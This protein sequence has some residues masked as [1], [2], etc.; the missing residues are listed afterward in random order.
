M[1]DDETI[2]YSALDRWER[3]GE[4]PDPEEF[5]AMQTVLLRMTHEAARFLAVID[6]CNHAEHLR[7]SLSANWQPL[8]SS[9]LVSTT[10]LSG[11]SLPQLSP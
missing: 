8:R 10:D 1:T 9:S 5:E 2:A 4:Y 7:R 11:D 6:E 3:E